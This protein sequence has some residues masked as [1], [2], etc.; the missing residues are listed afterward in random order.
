MIFVKHLFDVNRWVFK[1]KIIDVSYNLFV[2]FYFILS[3]LY[4]TKIVIKQ[5]VRV[6]LPLDAFNCQHC[7]LA[8]VYSFFELLV[9][10]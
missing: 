2:S 1:N 9:A 10:E 6:L 5:T 4:L 3:A 7:I 8:V